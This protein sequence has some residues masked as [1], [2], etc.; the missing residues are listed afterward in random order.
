MANEDIE[1]QLH[2][3]TTA[4]VNEL[5]SLTPETMTEIQ[6]ELAATADGG[7]DIGLI[8]NHPDANKVAL[9]NS[10]YQIASRYL[11]LVKQ[12]RKNW[13]RSLITASETQSGWR[14]TVE[15]E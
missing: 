9:S 5:V 14:V 3:L 7:A 1:T 15:F 8:E 6:F 12:Y 2:H 4:L 13:R 11:P 10:V